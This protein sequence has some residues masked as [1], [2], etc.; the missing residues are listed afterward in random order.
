MEMQQATRSPFVGRQR[1]LG[2]LSGALAG[3]QRGEGRIVLL[4]GE[5]GIGKT[6]LAEELARVAQVQ[7]IQTLWG[8]CYEGEGAPAFWPWVQILRSYLS[9][10]PLD[11]LRAELEASAAEIAQL[12]PELQVRLPDLPAPAPLPPEQARFRL[13]ESITSFLRRAAQR[14]PLVLVLDDLHWADTSSLLLLRFLGR[15]L[16]Q[17]PVVA[18]GAYRNTDVAPG[19]PLAPVLAD[20]AREPLT[21]RLQ[22]T[23]LPEAD[24]AS[25]LEQLAGRPLPPALAATLSAQAEGN[26]F[27]LAEIVRLLLTEGGFDHAAAS[28]ASH[29]T[30]PPKVRD[31]I[32]QRVERLAPE[33]RQTLTIAAVIGREFGTGALE[34][35]ASLDRE[36]L[37]DALDEAENVALIAPLGSGS[38]RYRFAHALIRETLYDSLPAARRARLHR[39]VGEALEALWG[40]YRGPRIAELAYHFCQAAPAGASEQ[41]IRY[42]LQAAARARRLLAYD[43]AVEFLRTARR[44]SAEYEPELRSDILCRLALV[45]AEALLLESAQATA[46]EAIEALEESAASAEQIAAFLTESVRALKEGGAGRPAWEPL[47]RHGLSRLGDRRGLV[48]ARLMLLLDPLEPLMH[49][50][51]RIYRWLGYEPEAVEI[52]RAEG[53]ERDYAATL[54]LFDWRTRA[55][56]EAILVLAR[57]WREPAA[58]LRGLRIGAYDLLMR[59]GTYREA[60][61][62]FEELLSTA[63]R[64]GSIPEQVFALI[65]LVVVRG[66]L[67]EL[68]LARQAEVRMTVL[69]TRLGPDHS[70]HAVASLVRLTAV[71]WSG[72]DWLRIA[73]EI[74]ERMRTAASVLSEQTFA[75]L[76]ALAYANAGKIEAANRMLDD[77]TPLLEQMQPSAWCQSCVVALAGSVVVLLGR[78]DLASR[79][80]RLALDLIAAG[81]ADFPLYSNDATV[82]NM[83]MLLGDRAEAQHFYDRARCTLE[84]SG[85]RLMRGLVDEYEALALLRSDPD[86]RTRA[87]ALLDAALAQFQSLGMDPWARR[88]MVMQERV[89]ASTHRLVPAAPAYPDGLT[90]REVEVLRLIAAGKTTREIAGALVV[91]PYTVE[92]HITNLYAK[93]GVRGR[94]GAASYAL[95]HNL[96]PSPPA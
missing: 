43:E 48:W 85:Q 37:L 31:V 61:E 4:A 60:A 86:D 94:A 69:L 18:V 87:M 34:R 17:M 26:P 83:A 38:E 68:E 66:A 95:H 41:A 16:R 63:A 15:E 49:G 53:D 79:Y 96:V 92:R 50:A 93:A 10:Q 90:A 62:R 52:A 20:L 64:F 88:I 22:L 35:S 59:H 3:A 89:R 5:P 58:V 9:D 74:L 32:W 44:L 25:L 8:R 54:E 23:G 29:P 40:A 71:F 14:Q 65:H 70:L 82:A 76:A 77:L 73:E 78:R 80:R 81:I 51:L 46:T 7:A 47:V 36:Q 13:Y 11:V 2:E 19:H 42:A 39:Q 30:V 1:E 28:I 75:A 57:T 33:S 24:L 56:T 55:E 67:G 72:G 84:V 27:F 21:L 6:R 91:S 45:E 12:V